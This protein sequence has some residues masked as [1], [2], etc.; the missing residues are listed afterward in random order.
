MHQ[1]ELFPPRTEGLVMEEKKLLS[2]LYCILPC[3]YKHIFPHQYTN[4][5]EGIT[6]IFS[7]LPSTCIAQHDLQKN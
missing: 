3:K 5:A 2:Q 7:W 6:T 4:I 1:I